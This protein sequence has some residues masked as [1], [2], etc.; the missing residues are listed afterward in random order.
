MRSQAYPNPS[1]LGAAI[2]GIT[3]SAINVHRKPKTKLLLCEC[4]LGSSF[5]LDEA[6]AKVVRPGWETLEYFKF[7]SIWS[8]R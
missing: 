8:I 5:I 4:R 7:D 3:E 2:E 6:L 1:S